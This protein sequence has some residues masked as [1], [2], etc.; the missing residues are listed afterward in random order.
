MER[1]MKDVLSALA[2]IALLAA[3]ACS[4]NA[5]SEASSG[6]PGAADAAT[7]TDGTPSGHIHLTGDV[8]IDSDFM[9]DACQI[10]PAGEGLLSGYHMMAKEQDALPLL[11]VTIKNYTKDDTYA[12]TDTSA[13]GQVTSIMT[14]GSLG[15]LTLMVLPSGTQIPVGFMLKPTSKLAVTVSENGAKGDAEFTGLETPPKFDPTASTPP[16]GGVVSGS[17]TWSCGHID[18]LDPKMNNAVNG[19]FKSLIH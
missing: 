19:M 8:S 5:N 12:P 9:P 16:Q 11:A 18:H 3:T 15:L 17:I 10:A 6:D 13:D 4:G 2:F 7:S 1:T 14:S